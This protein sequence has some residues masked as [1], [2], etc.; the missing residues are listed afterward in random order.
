MCE[1]SEIYVT[2]L[3]TDLPLQ[4]KFEPIGP[5]FLRITDINKNDWID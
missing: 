5:K 3:N 2:N 1:F 4:L